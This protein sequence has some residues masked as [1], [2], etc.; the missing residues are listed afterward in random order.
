M[1][2]NWV[3]SG[4]VMAVEFRQNI[5]YVNIFKPE[6]ENRKNANILLPSGE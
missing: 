4:E 5:Y 6:N 3:V 1:G 2:V